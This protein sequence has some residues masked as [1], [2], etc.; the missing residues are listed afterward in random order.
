MEIIAISNIT[1]LKSQR[2]LLRFIGMVQLQ[3]LHLVA[4]QLLLV[5]Q[6]QVLHLVAQLLLMVVSQLQV[7]HLVAQQV[8]SV[9]QQQLLEGQLQSFINY[10]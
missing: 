4:Q 8:Y 1:T 6:L 2:E 10:Y 3:V 5:A 9:A 7:L